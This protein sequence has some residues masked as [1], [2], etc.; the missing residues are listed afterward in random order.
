MAA[1]VHDPLYLPT[2]PKKGLDEVGAS[3]ALKSL[4]EHLFRP[5]L[6][7]RTL[8]MALK[9]SHGT[10]LGRIPYGPAAAARTEFT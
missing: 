7:S 9:S 4:I 10:I 6:D 5:K 1:P 3:C 2:D 8:K